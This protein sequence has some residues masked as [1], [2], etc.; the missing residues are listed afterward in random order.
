ML[1][2]VHL[3]LRLASMVPSAAHSQDAPDGVKRSRWILDTWRRLPSTCTRYW[4]PSAP[5]PGFSIVPGTQVC[6]LPNGPGLLE[7]RP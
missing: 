3:T 7:K 6:R 4:E 5:E 2:N 1:I